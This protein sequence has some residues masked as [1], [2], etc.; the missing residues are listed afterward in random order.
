M[1]LIIIMQY[2]IN[3]SIIKVY[4]N[5]ELLATLKKKKKKQPKIH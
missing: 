5:T 2:Q 1:L 4:E 3:Q